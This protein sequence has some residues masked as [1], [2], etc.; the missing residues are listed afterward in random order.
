M[1][2]RYFHAC[3]ERCAAVESYGVLPIRLALA[4]TFILHGLQKLGW[5]GGGR[6]M[7]GT[8]E[9]F[10]SLGLGP[11]WAWLVT[12]VELIGG[13]MVLFGVATEIASAALLITMIVAIAKVHWTKG[14]FNGAGGYEFNLLIIAACLALIFRG[15]GQLSVDAYRIKKKPLKTET[16][17][18]SGT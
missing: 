18:P 1:I 17:P 13:G 5:V 4:A 10:S 8:I 11:F 6:G 12:L 14:F 16:P 15:A 3:N 9:F 7:E 2:C